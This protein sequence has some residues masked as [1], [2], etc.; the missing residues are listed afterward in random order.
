MAQKGLAFK[1]SNISRTWVLA[2]WIAGM[3]IMVINPILSPPTVSQN[4]LNFIHT[5]EFVSTIRPGGSHVVIEGGWTLPYLFPQIDSLVKLMVKYG[6][7]IY[8]I[9]SSAESPYS[10]EL[11]F[12][13]ANAEIRKVTYGVDYVIFPYQTVNQAFIDSFCT[14]LWSVYSVDYYGKPFT[15]LPAMQDF[16]SSADMDL[17][18]PT[19]GGCTWGE[20]NLRI[21]A[22]YK[23]YEATASTS[24]C[25][26]NLLVYQ[27]PEPTRGKPSGH[28]DGCFGAY[29][30]D[31]TMGFKSSAASII[32]V[33][34]FGTMYIT[35]LMLVGSVAYHIERS[36]RRRQETSLQKG[37]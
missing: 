35:V 22:K 7:T 34:Q 30:I 18:F 14:D 26:T 9:P 31:R 23:I 36:G 8:V 5:V 6:Y 3:V 4:A 15:S 17:H 13:K 25:T 1:L 28:I 24:S 27:V 20:T 37:G 32:A 29:E 16:H 33:E 10:V 21:W 2:M 11:A 12:E 19:T